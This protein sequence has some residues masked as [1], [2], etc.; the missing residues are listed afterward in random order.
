MILRSPTVD[1]II[2]CAIKVHKALGPGLLESAYQ[3]C[4]A[5]ELVRSGLTVEREIALPLTY[6]DVRLDCGYRVDFRINKEVILEVKSV[7]RVLP[8]HK[9][10]LLT[11]LRLAHVGQGL[12]LNFHAPLLRHGICS[13]VLE[14]YIS[15]SSHERIHM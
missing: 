12:L 5:Y 1:S 14:Q 11:Y 10:Q 13:V 7:E 6:G 2:G 15:S 4:L 8:I 9:A 3:A